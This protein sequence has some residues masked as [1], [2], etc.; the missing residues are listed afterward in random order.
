MPGANPLSTL[1]DEYSLN[2]TPQMVN[3]PQPSNLDLDGI[4]PPRY[5]DNPPG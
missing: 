5:L 3:K 1:H 2:G 4:T